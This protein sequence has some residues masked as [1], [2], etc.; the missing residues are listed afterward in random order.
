MPT[1]FHFWYQN[2]RR[3]DDDIIF[4]GELESL[5]CD[6]VK[7]DGQRCKRRCVI[8]LPCCHSHLPIKYHI[9]IKKSSIDVAGKGLFAKDKSHGD[10]G[11]VFKKG[12]KICPYYGELID[13]E[14]LDDRY[15]NDKLG[16]TAPYAVAVHRNQF[17]DGALRRGV[18]SLI[19]HKPRGQANCELSN[20][21]K[22]NR[23]SIR[24]LKNIRNGDELFLSYGRSY[25]MNL[26]YVHYDTNNRKYY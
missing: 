2:P 5:R 23:I 19:N 1:Y 14:T 11:I 26:P 25:Q 17:E 7:L 22:N 24:A 6:F 21:N 8:G 16:L 13:R 10:F 20:P 18:G 12:D 15:G 4:N 3:P 9:E